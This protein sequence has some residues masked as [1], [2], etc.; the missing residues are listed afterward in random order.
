MIEL[1]WDAQGL[2]PAV[3][4]DRRSGQVRMLAW[5]NREALEAT[6]K[7]GWATFFSRSRQALWVKGESS[8]HKLRVC[9]ISADCDADTLLLSVEAEG[10]SCHTGRESC[11]FSQ[12]DGGQAAP[13]RTILGELERT[14]LERSASTA[15]RSYT[16]RLLDAGAGPIGEKLREEADELAR[17]IDGEETERVVSEAADV[18]FHLLVGLRSRGL[19]LSEVAGELARRAGTSGLEEKAARDRG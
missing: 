16:K 1:K 9:G 4:Q 15:D 18:M 3:A 14:I 17:A 19:G 13:Q 10:P 2:I 7:T 6:L 5:M 8:G 12:I 11:F